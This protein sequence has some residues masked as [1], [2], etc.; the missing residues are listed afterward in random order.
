M[1]MQFAHTRRAMLVSLTVAILLVLTLST[2]CGGGSLAGGNNGGNGNS[3]PPPPPPPPPPASS[4]T[5]TPAN[6]IVHAGQTVTFTAIV[7]GTTNQKVT[8]SVNGITGG[9]TTVGTIN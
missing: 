4:V 9:N 6:I 5:L 7:N 2:G 1:M 3:T 8:W